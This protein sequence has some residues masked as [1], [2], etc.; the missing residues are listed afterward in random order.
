[1]K[2]THFVGSNSNSSKLQKTAVIYYRS[3]R[4][5]GRHAAASATLR[6]VSSPGRKFLEVSALA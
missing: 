4:Q 2:F 1:L 6:A 3:T 5:Q